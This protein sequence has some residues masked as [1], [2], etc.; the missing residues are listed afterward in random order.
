MYS[1]LW[2]FILPS[3]KSISRFLKGI[4]LTLTALGAA[5]GANA[6][7]M[8]VC[9][10]TGAGSV[11]FASRDS[12]FRMNPATPGTAT[13]TG[14]ILP[15]GTSGS[16]SGLAVSRNLNVATPPLTYY[17]TL[18][19]G[20]NNIVHFWDGVTWVSTGHVLNSN[21]IAGGGGF[22]FSY[23]PT[24][25]QV[26]KYNP[27]GLP[28]TSFVVDARGATVGTNQSADIAADCSG[29]FYVIFQGAT[30]AIMKKFSSA[31]A[32][33]ATYTLTGTFGAGAGGLAVNGNNVFYD[34][35]D[36]KLYS[37]VINT[38][39]NTV[40]FS[41]SAGTPFA[42][43]SVTDFG[44][45]GYAGYNLDSAATDTVKFCNGANNVTLSATGPGPYDWTVLSGSATITGTG[46]TVTVNSPTTSV[47][48]HKDANCSGVS[49]LR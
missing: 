33:L 32:P 14:I 8:P 49:T 29:N 13:F 40:N 23:E 6:Q 26:Y 15:S 27:S 19:N 28:I 46:S 30:P 10:G 9:S 42:K 35:A 5:F 12:I 47:I 36:N 2:A 11:Y 31:G 43:Y 16:A 17:T 21:H 22:L 18:S 34:G 38:A 45:C 1:A 44:S 25:G 48:V 3:M 24:T 41:A 20:T 39:T 4:T 37:G 7:T